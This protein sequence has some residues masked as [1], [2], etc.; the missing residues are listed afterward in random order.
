M[1]ASVVLRNPLV[2]REV[3]YALGMALVGSSG[4]LRGSA[5]AVVEALGAPGALPEGWS[6]AGSEAEQGF[7]VRFAGDG[8]GALEVHLEPRDEARPCFA[9]TRAF[10]V[11]YA[12]WG[13]GDGALAPAEEALLGAVLRALRRVEGALP[14]APVEDTS[15]RVAVRELTVDRVL[16]TEAP[17]TYYVN[18][19]AGCLLACTYCYAIGRT[20]FS[21]ALE[22]ARRVPW[23]RWLDVKVNAPEVL[24]RELREHPPGSVRLS[25]IVTDP[26]QAVERRY[27]VTRGC[28]E[29]L[30]GS[31]FLTVLLTRSTRVLEDLPR[32]RAMDNVLVGMSVPT[33]DDQVRRAFEPRTEPID[34]RVRA[35]ALLREAGVRTFAVVHPMLPLD[36]E[37][38]AGRLGPHVEAVRLGPMS[39]KHR[40]EGT[41]A[42]LGR[43]EALT[44]TWER[45]TARRLTEALTRQGVLV[46]PTTPPWNTFR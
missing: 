33:D 39:E 45:D 22:G 19:Y 37:A 24:A 6:L 46:D 17:R 28:L 30:D 11:Y 16:M 23:G 7:L 42:R 10:N 27:R 15:E 8:G 21:R 43:E 5:L 9:S 35:L 31:G 40:V 32:L 36:P 41:Y 25:P 4:S 13:R 12:R 44:P 38:L 29:A 20:A 18:P 34:A 26:Y 2:G 3:R 14:L 1:R